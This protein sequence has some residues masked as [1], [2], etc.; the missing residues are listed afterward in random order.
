M[1]ETAS[2]MITGTGVVVSLLIGAFVFAR[3]RKVIL[4]IL[5]ACFAVCVS[6]LTIANYL[7]LFG[8]E[9][10]AREW[11]VRVVML[12]TTV[13]VMLVYVILGKINDRAWRMGRG[14]WILC[15][16][17]LV[18]V[19][20]HFTNFFLI[21]MRD[22]TYY[23]SPI[24]GPGIILFFVHF[25]TLLALSVVGLFHKF[26]SSQGSIHNRSKILII[27]IMP[28]LLFAPVT[29]IVLPMVFSR[30]TLI[31]I[32]PLYIIFFLCCVAYAIV[33]H[34]LFDIRLATIRTVGY[35][36]TIAVMAGIYVL[37]AY[38]MSVIFFGGAVTDGVGL[39]PASIAIAL[40]LAFIF[41]PI[42]QFFDSWT[43][44]IFYRGTYSRE[45]FVRDF[46]KIIS[47]DTD[48][49]LLLKQSSAYIRE[50]LGAEGVFFYVNGRTVFAV[51]SKSKKRI[52]PTDVDMIGAYYHKNYEFPAVL[53]SDLV[54]SDQVRRVLK[55]YQIY[56]VL[57]L[58]LQGQP[59]GYLFIG[60]HKS[61]GYTMRDVRVIES[62]ANEL[63]I[64]VQNSL[65]V[66]EIREL[67][68]NLQQRVESATK[69]LRESNRQLQRL[70]EAKTEFI[71]M[72]SH[73]L[74]TP[75][76]SIKGYLDMVLQGD[77][78]KVSATQR[79]VLSEAF[80][81]SE[82]MV[83]LI[84]D[85]LNVSRLQTGKFVIDRTEGDLK[86][87]VADQVNMLQVIAKQHDLVIKETVDKDVPQMNIDIDKLRQ[88]IVNFIDNAIYYS[89]PGTA[90]RVKLARDKHYVEFTV[91][92]TGIGVPEAEKSKLFTRF[93]RAQNARRRRPDGTG[94]GL[95]LAKKVVMLHGGEIIFESE[96]GKGSTFGFRLP[97]LSTET[98]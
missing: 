83:T 1:L 64:A 66:E 54:E 16:L 80:L 73:Q 2:L 92:D 67:N 59:I 46:G 86:E 30:T 68:E 47:Y 14:D 22:G 98:D 38:A 51:N 45:I 5:F 10:P 18:V 87:V 12:M 17:T 7:S 19:I 78:G 76:T 37:L 23:P 62:I 41:Q 26:I 85:F 89:K 33:R 42:K 96:E 79:T 82:R 24:V 75:L 53:V 9:L 28:T 57:P 55:A 32:S 60:E 52:L 97:I 56:M 8:N 21:D 13:L 11:G 95:F 90:I 63:A 65:S 72:A 93:F 43:N 94:V 74:R 69:E 40:I 25:V 20:L 81:S 77:L 50:T 6:V 27:G 36:L 4:N 49:L 61:R 71:S 88:V 44:K 48:L 39:S 58:I 91:K 3:D 84:N 70:D 15:I 29:S 31:S 34:G 35:A